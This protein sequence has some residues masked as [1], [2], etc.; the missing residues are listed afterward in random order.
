MA[1][2]ACITCPVWFGD[3]ERKKVIN[4]CK[5][6]DMPCIRVIPDITAAAIQYG[7]FR[8]NQ[9]S[10]QAR[11]V[12]II[13]SGFSKTTI[14]LCSFKKTELKMLSVKWDRN[15]GARNFDMALMA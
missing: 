6:A 14:A 11:L 1:F 5:I 9:M 12:L 3:I 4:A 2:D 8:K 13:D 15:L 7:L 10:D